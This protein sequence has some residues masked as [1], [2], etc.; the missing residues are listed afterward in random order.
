MPFLLQEEQIP[1]GGYALQGFHRF[2]PEQYHQTLMIISE[3]QSHNAVVIQS[4]FP[5]FP[6]SFQAS[7]DQ[8]YNQDLHRVSGVVTGWQTED[9]LFPAE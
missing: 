3:E 1:S 5:G 2:H 8:E 6:V 4:V 7:D 9:H